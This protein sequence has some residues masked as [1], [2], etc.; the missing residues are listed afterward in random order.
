[1]EVIS[2]N[3]ADKVRRICSVLQGHIDMQPGQHIPA[4]S[5]LLRRHLKPALD[6]AHF[7]TRSSSWWDGQCFVRRAQHALLEAIR[8]A[9][10]VILVRLSRAPGDLGQHIIW[11]CPGPYHLGSFAYV[12]IM[13]GTHLFFSSFCWGQLKVSDTNFYSAV[14]QILQSQHNP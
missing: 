1:M 4:P 9:V 8:K 7:G 11:C 6:C 12:N 2:I 5:F 13:H 10:S 3:L 14:I